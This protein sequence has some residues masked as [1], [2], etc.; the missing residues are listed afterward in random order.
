MT[1]AQLFLGAALAW[2]PI[3][4]ALGAITRGLLP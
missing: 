1:L 2:L 4:I 3:L